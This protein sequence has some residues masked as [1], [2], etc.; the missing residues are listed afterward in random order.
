MKVK[1]WE[2]I[3]STGVEADKTLESRIIGRYTESPGMKPDKTCE[4]KLLEGIESTG[5]EADKTF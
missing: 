1:L 4:S 5:V 3:E 2:S